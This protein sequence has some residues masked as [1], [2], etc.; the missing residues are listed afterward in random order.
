MPKFEATMN[1]QAL[2][3]VTSGVLSLVGLLLYAR[4]VVAGPSKPSRATWLIW[5]LNS[6]LLLTSYDASG[7][8][9]T[10]WLA[11]GYAAGC[12]V[13]AMLTIK[14]GEGGWSRLD[15]ICLVGA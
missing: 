3:G 12:F 9:E 2:F 13:I 6:I 14:F 5:T 8:K 11:G 10:I 15:R 7:A 4:G 1:W